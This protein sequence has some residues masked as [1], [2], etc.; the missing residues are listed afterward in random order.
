MS[1]L[2]RGS[3]LFLKWR[4]VRRLSLW[5]NPRNMP[6]CAII[7]I[8]QRR[9]RSHTVIPHHHRARRPLDTHLK[10]LTFGNVIVEEV[11][12]VL[13]L[14]LFEADNAPAELGV[15]EEGF[16]ARGRVRADEWVDGSDGVA[17]DDAAS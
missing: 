8:Q 4:L 5:R 3:N 13:A 16:F 2:K 12:Q 11:E 10:V 14:L 17:A 15:Y 9:M 7:P 1:V 6:T